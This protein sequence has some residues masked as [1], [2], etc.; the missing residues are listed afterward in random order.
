MIID[1]KPQTGFLPP[2]NADKSSETTSQTPL[3][4][5]PPPRRKSTLSCKCISWTLFVVISLFALYWGLKLA[6]MTYHQVR[7]PWSSLY[8]DPKKPY[9]PQDVVR[10]LVDKDQTFD[11]VAT[12]WLRTERP[13]KVVEMI[14]RDEEEE[15][16]KAEVGGTNVLGSL[17]SLLANRNDT[18]LSKDDGAGL[19]EKAIWTGTVFRKLRLNDKHVKSS[20]SF[21]VPTEIFKKKDLHSYDLRGS[22]VLIPTAPSPLDHISNYSSWIPETINYPPS[23]SWPE[24]YERTLAEEAIDAYGTFI[25]LLSFH[26]TK[27][28]CRPP[29]ASTPVE[30]VEEAEDDDSEEEPDDPLFEFNGFTGMKQKGRYDTHGHPP[31][32]SHPYIVTR[33]FLRVVDMT[34]IMNRRL[35]EKSQKQ[36]KAFACGSGL[37]V[38][39]TDIGNDWRMC[40]RTY[41]QHGNQEVKIKTTKK[42]E[43]SGKDMS[44]YFYAPY[45]SPLENSFGPLDLVPVPVNR[46]DC[47]KDESNDPVPDEEYVDITWNIAFSGRTPDKILLADTLSGSAPEYNMTDTETNRLITH[48]NVEISQALSGH[49]FRD[50]Y[51]PRRATSLMLT[52]Q[53]FFFPS[54]S[55]QLSDL[56]DLVFYRL[57]LN[58][59]AKPL[60]LHYWYSRSSTVGISVIGTI[61]AAGGT[62]LD[63]VFESISGA[64]QEEFSFYNF[65]WILFRDLIWQTFSLMM[66]KAVLRAEFYRSKYWIPFIRFA[67]AS[68]AERASQRTESYP[69]NRSKLLIFAAF[70]ALY[71]FCEYRDLYIVRPRGIPPPRNNVTKSLIVAQVL[72][73]LP[74]MTL[75]RLLQIIMNLRSR[76]FAGTYKSSAWLNIVGLLLVT[77]GQSP[78]IVGEA[79]DS[80][81]VTIFMFSELLFG[82]MMAYQAL[83]YPAVSQVDEE[84]DTK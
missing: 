39:V 53:A 34:K 76:K 48:S 52:G 43:K 32:Q 10:P 59:V 69:S 82:G 61:L 63:F 57:A 49:H 24:G 21:R 65:F 83:Q 15:E 81:A 18:R 79:K 40:T 47:S 74:A 7:E 8:Q 25:P 28:R 50:D 67:P 6:F 29:D 14:A 5:G 51:H 13:P 71:S 4:P 38:L 41:R 17:A 23:R 84:E 33:S 11:I 45:L 26:N 80:P 2:I 9:R 73:V 22:F 64:S 31:L 30:N 54:L 60:E 19:S 3:D 44:E 46:E 77:A 68:H 78:R 62:L 37:N 16:D 42:N 36:I 70:A 1:Q 58:V 66:L 55:T 27:S 20:V 75:G 56:I 72:V 35:Y 12:V